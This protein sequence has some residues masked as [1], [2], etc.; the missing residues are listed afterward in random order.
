MAAGV[1]RICRDRAPAEGGKNCAWVRLAVHRNRCAGAR[2]VER[3]GPIDWTRPGGASP[4]RLHGAREAASDAADPVPVLAAS[5]KSFAAAEDLTRA[6]VP[7]AR[8]AEEAGFRA[9]ERLGYLP[10]VKVVRPGC[11]QM[12]LERRTSRNPNRSC[13][14]FS[15]QRG[16]LQLCIQDF[17]RK[18]VV[19]KG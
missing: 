6:A 4:A 16:R 19:T 9:S 7:M 5:S 12:D 10:G 14:S 8:P 18:V 2:P 3:R 15:I 17:H 11:A 13:C 1:L